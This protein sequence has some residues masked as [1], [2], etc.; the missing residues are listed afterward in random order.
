MRHAVEQPPGRL[1]RLYHASIWGPHSVAPEDDRLASLLRIYLPL[2]Y[3][4]SGMFGIGGLLFGVPAI[5]DAVNP[6]ASNAWSQLVLFASIACFMGNAFPKYLWRFSAY[7]N[8]AVV[9][10]FA[11]YS[12][13]LFYLAF[14]QPP[15]D[16]HATDRAALAIG[17]LRLI[18]LPF[19]RVF[20]VIRDRER[21][22]WH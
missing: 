3:V 18:Y 2:T 10:L 5:F 13:A 15:L 19:W 11:T 4:T 8:A 6:L 9:M 12:G 7:G 1:T 14:H 22:G 21:F 17:S 16:E 20:D